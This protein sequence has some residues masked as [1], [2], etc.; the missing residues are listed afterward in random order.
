MKRWDEA[1]S[2]S[3]RALA[4]AYGPRKLALLATRADIYAGKGDREAA[5]K[6]LEEAIA[7]AEALPPGQRAES[8]IG[9]LKK[10]LEA[11]KPS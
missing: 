6:A 8:T 11:L 10:K 2:A 3:D 5:R 4:K 7:M 9:S 1:L